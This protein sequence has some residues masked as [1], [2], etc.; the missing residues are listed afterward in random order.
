MKKQENLMRLLFC[1]VMLLAA[2]C[3]QMHAQQEARTAN[4]TALTPQQSQQ[5]EV[6]TLG[7]SE[8]R[9]NQMQYLFSGVAP[10]SNNKGKGETYV[11]PYRNTSC[12]VQ[13]P[14]RTID[15][16]CNNISSAPCAGDFGSA[17]VLQV[18]E[19]PHVYD[20]SFGLVGTNRMN[21]RA[22]SNLIF[23]QECEPSSTRL[24]SFVFTWAQFLDHDITLTPEADPREDVPIPP[25]PGDML[26]TGIPFNRSA[27]HGASPREQANEITAWIDASNVYGSDIGRANCLR[28]MVDGKLRESTSANGPLLPTSP[29]PGAPQAGIFFAGD[30]RANEQPGL[31]ALHTLFVREHNR[32]CDDLISQGMTVDEDI[33]QAARKQVGALMQAITYNEF[34]PA[35]GLNLAPYNGYDN[36]I[37]PD[38]S[39]V[40][41]TAAFRIGHTMVTDN[42]PRYDDNGNSIGSYGLSQ[43]FFSPNLIMTNGI[44]DI[45][46]GLS[47]QF[48]E[49]VDTRIVDSI[50]TFLF[51]QMAMG[52]NG[53]GFDL[54][55]LNIQRGRDHGL[56]HYNAYRQH[57]RGN[58]AAN[59]AQI[60]GDPELQAALETAYGDVDDIDVWVGLLAEDRVQG[61][62]LGP[63]MHKI[64]EEQF[65]RLRDGDFYFFENDPAFSAADVDIISNT[66]LSDVIKRNTGI[67]NIKDHVFFAP[68]PT[69]TTLTG[70]DNIGPT[71][72][73]QHKAAQEITASNMIADQAGAVYDAGIDV[74]LTTGFCADRGSDFH[75]LIN[76]CDSTSFNKRED[77]N[78]SLPEPQLLQ[79]NNYPN[80]FSDQT[81]INCRL[82]EDGP[83]KISVLTLA[84]QHL[85]DVVDS[86]KLAAG[87]Y[88]YDFDGSRLSAGVYLLLIQ[89]DKESTTQKMVISR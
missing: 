57:Y 88:Q 14:N 77:E 49:E 15:G 59:F 27:D 51:P 34:L 46:I 61:T 74:T 10:A 44:E 8:E 26:T 66:L 30:G 76:G 41:S 4:T 35:L 55:A 79:V 28:S 23:E 48:Q 70:A 39:N 78:S 6:Q 45:L 56:D 2:S 31:T 32:I 13:A 33:Y 1:A 81:T 29:C 25:V 65:T 12:N 50:R 17:G 53:T 52:P 36:T 38:I 16:T 67:M 9:M 73:E 20:A 3:L 21:P 58:T 40:F 69:F 60:T 7:L 86:G 64:L 89:S 47:H 80:P 42:V 19:V 72:I 85:A 43:A 63:T 54:A 68:C 84:G 62:A 87:S 24:S 75:A 82:S 5:V 83:L 22:I 37:Q 11:G 71:E 18:R